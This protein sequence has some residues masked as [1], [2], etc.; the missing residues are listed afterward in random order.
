MSKKTLSTTINEK[1]ANND[2]NIYVLYALYCKIGRGKMW[3]SSILQRE[4]SALK[5]NHSY[6]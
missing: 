1:R 5:N 4:F 6:E 3:T 2:G